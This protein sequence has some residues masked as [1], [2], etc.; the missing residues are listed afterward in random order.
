MK[1]TAIYLL[2]P[3]N[4]INFKAQISEIKPYPFCL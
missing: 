1:A 3:Q 2:M 4:Y